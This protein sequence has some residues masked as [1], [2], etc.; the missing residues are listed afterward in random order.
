MLQGSSYSV[1]T[2]IIIIVVYT[3]HEPLLKIFFSSVTVFKYRIAPNFRGRKTFVIFV[4]LNGITKK[5]S[6]NI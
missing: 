3:A 6:T 1:S 5:F 4:T 2:Y